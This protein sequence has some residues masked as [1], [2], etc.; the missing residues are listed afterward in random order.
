[1][2]TGTSD[3]E[4]L[5]RQLRSSESIETETTHK[6]SGQASAEAGGGFNFLV[7][8]QGEAKAVLSSEN[9]TSK[10][11]REEVRKNPLAI[12]RQI[13]AALVSMR[14]A[15]QKH[16]LGRD[17]L[18]IIDGSEKLRFEVYE[19]LFIKNA[20]LLQSLSLNMLIAVP[21]NAYY[22]IEAAPSQ[23]FSHSLLIPMIKL[24]GPK[25]AR[26]NELFKKVIERRIQADLF[27]EPGVLDECVRYSGG[28]IRQLLRIVNAVIYKALGQR[29]SLAVAQ[30]A[31][32][33]EGS[34]LNQVVTSEHVKVLE[35]GLDNL[36]PNDP[37]VREMLLQLVLLKYNGNFRLNPLLTDFVTLPPAP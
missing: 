33:A 22:R 21:I 37:G 1:V 20:N 5:A 6:L 28:C 12:V 30:A 19:E 8:L 16:G 17:I 35:K 23:N 3:F 13:N 34:T 15:V 11:I 7:K 36:R 4:A 32:R 27:F 9:A 10:K 26:A 14:E 2:L 29:A 24:T 25:A 31:I 18:F